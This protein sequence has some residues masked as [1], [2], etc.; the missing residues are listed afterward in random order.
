MAAAADRLA[1]D[2][3]EHMSPELVLVDPAL[4]EDVRRQL[5]VPD[6]TIARI[7]RMRIDSRSS[8]HPDEVEGAPKPE[9]DQIPAQPELV[10]IT[11][12]AVEVGQRDVGIDDLIV[13]PTQHVEQPETTR[14]YYPTLPSPP[15]GA[16]FEDA[17]DAVLRQI[18]DHFEP[19]PP[20]TQR[21]PHRLLSLES[22]FAA[23]ASVAMYSVDVHLGLSYLPSW[24]PS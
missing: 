16:R 19:E 10:P 8:A 12:G 23:L 13:V 20:T 15:E 7:E 2:V 17:T 9:L 18:R 14:R 24:I 5:V 4:Y 11:A 22:T 1:G 21:R 3:L 6:D